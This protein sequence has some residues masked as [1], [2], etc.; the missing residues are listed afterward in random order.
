[1][2]FCSGM[3]DLIIFELNTILNGLTIEFKNPK[4]TGIV[5]QS[6]T[7]VNIKFSNRGYLTIISDNYDKIIFEI[8]NYL[9]TRR[10]KCCHCN[11]KC[12]STENLKTHIL[13]FHKK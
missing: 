5:S 9:S 11:I 6:Q 12:K 10:F 7:D 13:N 2:G 1:M 4:G 8:N 3:P